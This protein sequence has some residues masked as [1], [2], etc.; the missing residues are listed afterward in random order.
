MAISISFEVIRL[1]AIFF[2]KNGVVQNKVTLGLAQTVGNSRNRASRNKLSLN[3]DQLTL[4]ATY[5]IP[6]G[7]GGRR[8]Y[9]S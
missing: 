4:E 5:E 7:S 3:S 6:G 2:G 1:N 9:W 8:R